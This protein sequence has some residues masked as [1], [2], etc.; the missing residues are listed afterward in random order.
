MDAARVS[1]MAFKKGFHCHTRFELHNCAHTHE[2]AFSVTLKIFSSKI[3][4][5]TLGVTV[6]H[7]FL[8]MSLNERMH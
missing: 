7:K 3:S 5:N 4:F 6:S 1:L 2:N 8:Q